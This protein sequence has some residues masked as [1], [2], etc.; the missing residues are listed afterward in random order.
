MRKNPKG[1]EPKR[2][3]KNREILH[4]EA[5]RWIKKAAAGS[6]IGKPGYDEAIF[7]LADC[8]GNGTLG[9]AI[10]H[11]KAFSLYAQAA[12]Q[13]HVNSIYRS[14]VCYEVGAGTRR[15]PSRAI[16]FYKKAA[17]LG[18]SAAMFKIGTILLNGTLGQTK[19][20]RE[21]VNWLKRAAMQVDDTTP[22][23]LH[24]LAMLHQ[25]TDPEVAKFIVPVFYC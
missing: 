14:G 9:L 16:Q 11:D 8:Y 20:P 4:A 5:V 2:I 7:M 17:M 19:N 25:S 23:A 15:D 1:L 10:N 12:K 24:E 6:F 13:G 3:K 22:H 21:G 18:D